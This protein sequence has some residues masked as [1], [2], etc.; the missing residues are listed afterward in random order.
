MNCLQLISFFRFVVFV[1]AGLVPLNVSG[2][3]KDFDDAKRLAERVYA[4]H[5][6][7]FY[8]GCRITWQKSGKDLVD[9]ASCGYRARKDPVRAQRIEWE[10]VVP[11]SWFGQPM[12]CW[13]HGGRK[14]CSKKDSVFQRMEA[15]MHNLTPSVGEVN[16]DR[17][18]M[19]FGE[20]AAAGGQYGK[21]ATRV[22]MSADKVEPRDAVK[23]DAAR[24]AFYMSERYRVKLDAQQLQVLNQWARQDPVDKWELERDRRIGQQMGWRNPYVANGGTVASITPVVVIPPTSSGGVA[25]QV[26]GNRK[27]KLF[28]FS[29]CPGYATIKPENRV[30]FSSAGDAKANGFRLAG[31][32]N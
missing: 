2:A 32:C 23:G 4:D 20:V 7:E 18:N 11:A 28:H 21:C 24:I 1:V 10:H 5:P 3:P 27:S 19:P 22:D 13:K 12:S 26:R 17:G 8:C 15:D 14:N 9:W 31:N 6:E 29:H 25:A 16:G 30:V